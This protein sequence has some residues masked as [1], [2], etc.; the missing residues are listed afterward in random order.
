MTKPAA[1]AIGLLFFVMEAHGS[2]SRYT[3][4][5]PENIPALA[6]PSYGASSFAACDRMQR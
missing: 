3:P 6:M 5:T 4:P 1:F 2:D